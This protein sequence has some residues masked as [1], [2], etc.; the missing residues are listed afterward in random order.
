MVDDSYNF[1]E[2]GPQDF[3]DFGLG[4][5][6]VAYHRMATNQ[7]NVLSFP[8]SGT[9][10]IC[11]AIVRKRTHW[12]KGNLRCRISYTGST[13][14]T[15]PIAFNATPVPAATGADLTAVATTVQELIPGPATA[16]LLAAEY[17]YTTLVPVDSSHRIIALQLFRNDASASD[18]YAGAFY[19]AQ[20]LLEY[21]PARQVQ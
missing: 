5:S 14:S 16:S 3:Y 1:I 20:V 7:W 2:L 15:N 6:A 17:V 11:F 9:S 19:V 4:G 10:S 8:A 13:G 18:T 21:V 12:V